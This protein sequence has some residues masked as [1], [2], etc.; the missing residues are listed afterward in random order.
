MTAIAEDLYSDIG[1]FFWDPMGYVMYAYDWER[2]P[3]L[4]VVRLEEPWMSRYRSEYGPERWACEMFDS[5]RDDVT[6][7]NFDGSTPVAPLRYARS[8]GHGIGKSATVGMLVAWIMSTRPYAVGTVTAGSHHQLKTKT[9]PQIAKWIEK[10]ITG[11]WFEVSISGLWVRHKEY[12]TQ[13]QCSGV[14]CAKENADAFQGQHNVTSTSFYIFDEA[15]AVPNEIWEAA[16]GGLTDGEPMWFV[17]GNPVRNR[18]EFRECFRR[19]S[20]RWNTAQI[21]SRSCQ[22]TNK[23]YLQ[24]MIDDYGLDSDRVKVRVL[25]KFPASSSKQFIPSDLVDESM[26]RTVTEEDVRYAPGILTLDSA[27]SGDDDYVIGFRRGLHFEVLWTGQKIQDDVWLANILAAYEDQKGAD[28]VFIDFGYGT[29]TYSV[30]K[31]LGRS[32]TL[33]NYGSKSA[34][35]EYANKR[36]EMYG[37]GLQ[38]LKEGGKLPHDQMLADELS[39]IEYDIRLD[40]KK[41]LDDKD[42]VRNE[43]GRSPGRADAW[44]QSFAFPV[45]NRQ[46]RKS[47]EALRNGKKRDPM[48]YFGGR[49]A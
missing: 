12:P 24:E 42:K 29:G 19:D 41:I 44:A 3:D 27:W 2:D 28:A 26:R 22:L 20:R 21:D 11:S 5:I 10:S 15:S 14:S 16:R 35:R 32:W 46:D 4:S 8:S 9:F 47:I 48:S 25:G 6:R 30:G 1:R 33:V 36:A 18:G 43:I 40:G 45:L 37:L 34:D 39:A 23:A 38:W 17:F 49:V 7:N 13:W 31:A